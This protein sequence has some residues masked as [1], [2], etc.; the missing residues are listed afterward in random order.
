MEGGHIKPIIR[1]VGG[2]E[3]LCDILETQLPITYQEEKYIPKYFEPFVGGGSFL[4]HLLTQGYDIPYIYIS[5]VNKD[6]ILL[7]NIIRDY[8]DEFI[9]IFNDRLV[10]Y[11]K[12]Q[13]KET[14]YYNIRSNYNKNNIHLLDR[15]VDFVLLNKMCFNSLYR[16]N[17]KGEF[18]V[19][20]NRKRVQNPKWLKEED[21]NSISNALSN[22]HILHSDYFTSINFVDKSSF[23]YLDTPYEDSWNYNMES[24]NLISFNNFCSQCH[25]KGARFL[26]SNFSNNLKA[27][28]PT[29]IYEIKKYHPFIRKT[30]DEV[31]VRNYEV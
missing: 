1:W 29:Y 12:T 23:L 6:L 27:S 4:L 7:Y 14:Y 26:Y 30:K 9:Q 31:L 19:A 18:N 13:D 25:M 8:P 11:R 15:A 28:Y 24:D 22:A 21:V 3:P 2:K 10:D 5:D 20:Y 17:Q 16:V